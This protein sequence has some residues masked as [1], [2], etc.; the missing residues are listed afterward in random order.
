MGHGKKA[1]KRPLMKIR[2]RSLAPLQVCPKIFDFLLSKATSI[3]F[4]ALQ[5]I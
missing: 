2:L 4:K 3:L 1:W 5:R